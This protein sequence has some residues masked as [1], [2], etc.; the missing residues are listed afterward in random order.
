[1]EH[2]RIEYVMAPVRELTWAS[3]DDD[4]YETIKGAVHVAVISLDQPAQEVVRQ[5]IVRHI[6]AS[7]MPYDEPERLVGTFFAQ[8][9]AYERHASRPARSAA[10]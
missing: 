10:P 6:K 8:V 5:A 4:V 7:S 1:M 3:D 2:T 9:R